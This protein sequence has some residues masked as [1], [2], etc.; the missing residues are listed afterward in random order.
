MIR[1]IV[2]LAGLALGSGAALLAE[3][4]M[5]HLQR[6]AGAW[7]PGWTAG[8]APEASLR[9]GSAQGLD[10]PPLPGPVALRWRFDGLGA[11]GAHWML[12]FGD[13]AAFTGAARLALSPGG[14]LTLAGIT[15][16]MPLAALAPEAL[17]QRLGG[18][19][20]AE[21][22][23]AGLRP[24][25]PRAGTLRWIAPS[26]DGVLG[27]AEARL[28]GDATGWHAPFLL[29]GGSLAARGEILGR[30]GEAH[31][32]ALVASDPPPP[33]DWRRLLDALSARG[34]DGWQIEMPLFAG[35]RR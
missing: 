1:L 24:F 2:V 16:E 8:V 14:N 11:D 15:G 27:L 4:R 23:I 21:D 34:P 17:A 35:S 22:G 30:G 26:L 31:L 33:G 7:L 13:G 6:V 28:S 12:N 25:T 29:D 3:G 20:M 10:L 9:R 32:S 18:T 19:L 5:A